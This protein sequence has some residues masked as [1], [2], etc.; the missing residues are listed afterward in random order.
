MDP[1]PAGRILIPALLCISLPELQAPAHPGM[2]KSVHNLYYEI[3]QCRNDFFQDY[4]WLHLSLNQK[5]VFAYVLGLVTLAILRTQLVNCFS[6]LVPE[7][8]TYVLYIPEA[9]STNQTAQIAHHRRIRLKTAQHSRYLIGGDLYTLP[10]LDAAQ[11]CWDSR[12]K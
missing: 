3:Q 4:P 8:S 12:S 9:V 6:D 1:D 2:C 7:I 5:L 10:L 11:N